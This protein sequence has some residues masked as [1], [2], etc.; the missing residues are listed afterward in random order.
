LQDCLSFFRGRRDKRQRVRF[1]GQC[2]R[3]QHRIVVPL[4][5]FGAR[6]IL[7]PERGAIVTGVMA[8]Q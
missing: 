7:Y 4:S 2:A 8:E 1:L 5:E 6:K 3:R